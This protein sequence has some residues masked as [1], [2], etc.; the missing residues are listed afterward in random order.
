MVDYFEFEESDE[1]EFIMRSRSNSYKGGILNFVSAL[2]LSC[3]NLRN[4][5]PSE[6]GYLNGIIAINLSHNMIIGPIPRTLS[7][8]TQIVSL[9]LSYYKLS[10]EIPFEMSIF[11]S[12]EVFKVTHN[13]LFGK[14]PEMKNQFL[15]FS[16]TSYEGNPFP[17]GPPLSRL[18]SSNK[19]STIPLATT[20]IGVNRNNDNDMAAFFISFATSYIVFFLGFAEIFYINPYW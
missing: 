10:W 15:M 13:N 1:V 9:D 7:N 8:I 5:T 6:I 2:D 20:S 18:C 16:N 14:T 19:E 17:C 11:Y 4:E 3:N 12:L